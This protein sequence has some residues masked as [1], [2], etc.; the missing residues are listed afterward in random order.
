[1]KRRIFVVQLSAVVI[2]PDQRPDER[3][4]LKG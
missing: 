2:H 4:G 3:R 1:M